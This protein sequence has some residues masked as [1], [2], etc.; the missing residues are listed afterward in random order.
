[1]TADVNTAIQV[2]GLIG[3]T[4]VG[5]VVGG[6]RNDLRDI[7]EDIKDK[8]SGETCRSNREICRGSLRDIIGIRSI[9][10]EHTTP[11]DRGE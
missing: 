5:W 3:I 2:I 1:M 9:R 6:I 8:I 7:R 11:A 10:G 4:I